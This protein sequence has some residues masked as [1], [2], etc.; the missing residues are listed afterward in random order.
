MLDDLAVLKSENIDDRATARAWLANG[1]DM[2]DHIVAV[3]KHFLDLAVR[4]WQLVA[5]KIKKG[6]EP[7]N[8][9]G[10]AGIVLDVFRPEIFRG[11]L[12]ILLVQAGFIEFEHRLLVRLHI[13]GE[14]RCCRESQDQNRN[15]P[16]H[17]D[18]L[19]TYIRDGRNN[20]MIGKTIRM[21]KRR[22]SVRMN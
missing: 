1:M 11:G 10:C 8:A 22:M 12:E 14:R 19:K 2:Q 9:V 7:L 20:A 21:I 3:G 5:Q 13:G 16:F 6:F 18:L 17:R 4:I 15:D